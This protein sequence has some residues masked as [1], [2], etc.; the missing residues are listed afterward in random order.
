[1]SFHPSLLHHPQL[2]FLLFRHCQVES[3]LCLRR[4]DTDLQEGVEHYLL[5]E[6][7]EHV[8]QGAAYS[9]TPFILPLAHCLR[10]L[11]LDHAAEFRANVVRPL[12]LPLSA[13]TSRQL[14]V[15]WCNLGNTLLPDKRRFRQFTVPEFAG[16]RPKD[17]YV[18]SLQ[19]DKTYWKAW[20]NL[21][22]VL[23]TRL[24]GPVEINGD[25]FDR[26]ACAQEGIR[27]QQED[28]VDLRPAITAVEFDP[29][30]SSAWCLVAELCTT[31]ND[32]SSDH[33]MNTRDKTYTV[34]Q[35]VVKALHLNMDDPKAWN[36]LVQAFESRRVPSR[37]VVI[38]GVH[39]DF[40]AVVVKLYTLNPASVN[41]Y[42]AMLHC[43]EDSDESSSDDSDQDGSNP[44][45]L[46]WNVQI[47]PDFRV[48]GYI[49]EFGSFAV[50]PCDELGRLKGWL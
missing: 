9:P 20:R 44:Q 25:Y 45:R 26:D 18:K 33:C 3:L 6:V 28:V 2:R 34:L 1:M 41:Q 16:L 8:L 35:C 40:F 15:L 10:T 12:T 47:G 23:G 30:N 19:C 31:K 38:R 42:R 17:C 37:H 46:L 27:H 11:R 5:D 21:S 43:E 4:V 50:G 22:G 7:M 36:L 13:R 32:H 29:L 39:F 14:S 49:D 48:A 24:D